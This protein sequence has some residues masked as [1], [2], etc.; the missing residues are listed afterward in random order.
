MLSPTLNYSLTK[1]LHRGKAA[2]KRSMAWLQQDL[3]STRC[4]MKKNRFSAGKKRRENRHFGASFSQSGMQIAKQKSAS[5]Q[6]PSHAWPSQ[7]GMTIGQN[8]GLSRSPK[9]RGK[10]VSFLPHKN[11]EFPRKKRRTYL[12]KSSKIGFPIAFPFVL[13]PAKKKKRK[14]EGKESG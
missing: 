8:V 6:N 4:E 2:C 11:A 12:K 3:L 5:G 7:K 14:K 1:G 9:L 13:L 10:A